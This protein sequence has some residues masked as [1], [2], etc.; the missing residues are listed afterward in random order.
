MQKRARAMMK[1]PAMEKYAPD[2]FLPGPEIATDADLLR[3]VGDIASYRHPDCRSRCQ[4]SAVKG[5]NG[6]PLTAIP[7]RPCVFGIKRPVLCGLTGRRNSSDCA[8]MLL[9]L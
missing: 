9:G 8:L 6:T 5:S 4:Y 3:S 7:N 2:E 1:M